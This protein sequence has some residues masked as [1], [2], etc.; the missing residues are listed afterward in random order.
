MTSPPQCSFNKTKFE[1]STKIAEMVN[2][3]CSGIT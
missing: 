2:I 1:A 3:P